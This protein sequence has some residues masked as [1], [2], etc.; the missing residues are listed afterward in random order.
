M[1][2]DKETLFIRKFTL[3]LGIALALPSLTVASLALFG[4]DLV[5][6]SRWVAG[7]SMAVVAFV[8]L[9]VLIASWATKK[10]KDADT[11]RVYLVA[12]AVLFVSLGMLF[13]FSPRF[14]LGGYALEAIAV[15]VALVG[16]SFLVPRSV[17]SEDKRYTWTISTWSVSLGTLAAW[18]I[19]MQ[20]LGNLNLLGGIIV[21]L[22]FML[23]GVLCAGRF[24]DHVDQDPYDVHA[25][26]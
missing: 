25:S 20:A 21:A 6:V 3:S 4:Q 26:S 24:A 11:L 9:S 5:G 18:E 17:L 23:V 1:T 14:N 16:L 19:G 8:F 12:C 10:P 7:L 2:D 13:P 22:L 15:F